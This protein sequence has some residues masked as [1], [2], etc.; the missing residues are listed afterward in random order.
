MHIA[1]CRNAVLGSLTLLSEQ[2]ICSE[3]CALYQEFVHFLPEENSNAVKKSI[4][5]WDVTLHSPVEVND[6]SKEHTVSFFRV[7]Q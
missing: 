1:A 5:F 7:G 3:T 2:D 4:I 6:I